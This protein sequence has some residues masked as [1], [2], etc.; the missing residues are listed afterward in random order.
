MLMKSKQTTEDYG[1]SSVIKS[2]LFKN[3][4]LLQF[5][6]EFLGKRAARSVAI[7]GTYCGGDSVHVGIFW[8]W[9]NQAKIFHFNSP[10]QIEHKDASE[11][12]FSSFFF[13]VISD[14]KEVLIPSIA[15]IANAIAT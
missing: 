11:P 2:L 1:K 8:S 9:D 12:E 3:W 6:D 5:R 13:N 10:R 15:G 7:C 4:I 14:F